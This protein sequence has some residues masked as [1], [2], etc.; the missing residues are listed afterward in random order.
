[1]LRPQPLCPERVRRIRAC[2]FGWIDHRMLA[3]GWL[4]QLSPEALRLYVFL[5]LVADANGVSW[6]SYDRICERLQMTMADYLVAR[7][8]LVAHALVSQAHGVFQVLALPARARSTPP[9]TEATM[10]DLERRRDF[11]TLKEILSHLTPN[12]KEKQ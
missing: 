4:A 5:V 2:T 8:E 12:A 1:M 3:E 9:N 7:D 11:Q 10:R 6:Y